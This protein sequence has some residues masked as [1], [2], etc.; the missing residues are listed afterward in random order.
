MKVL[1]VYAEFPI[2]YWGFQ[3]A[4]E[5]VGQKATLPP[6]GL[7]TLAAML[8]DDWPVR[9]IDLNAHTLNDTDIRWAD[10]VMVGGMLIQTD[11]MV[12][13]LT[14]A[15]RLGKRTVVGGP[16]PTTAP[17]LFVAADVVF[18][19]EA[20]GRIESLAEAIAA[21]GRVTLDAPEDRPD[22]TTSPIPRYN[23]LTLSD[24]SSVSLQYSRGCP[25]LCEF[26]DIIEIF[27]RRPRVKDAEQVF[28]EL[29]A[30][31]QVG[32]R[33]RIFFVDDN[34]IGNRR[35]VRKML[36]SI[37]AFQKERNYP[38]SFYTEATVDLASDTKLTAEMVL[39]GF[40]SV[41]LGI[42]TPSAASLRESGKTQNLRI[43]LR[44]AI[45]ILT[46]AGLEIMGGFIVG[47]DNDD[48][49]IFRLQR[50]FISDAPIPL[51]MVG[52]LAALPGTALWRRLEKEGRLRSASTGDQ[53]GRPNFEP[54]MDERVLLEGY[55]KLMAEVYSAESYY[56]RCRAHIDNAGPTPS[57]QAL[58]S[59]A[60]MKDFGR[61][62]VK[63]GILSPRR[64]QF[65]SLLAH[66]ARRS[67]EKLEWMIIHAFQG[68]H[69]IRYTDEHVIPRLEE[70]IREAGRE[71]A[72]AAEDRGVAAR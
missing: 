59:R 62:V 68:E 26:C 69:L 67:P 33:G 20:E 32:Y 51:A 25:Y 64:R 60:R 36:P 54:N 39:A 56:R 2:T 52:L 46:E 10:V 16:A 72:R 30:L 23:L 31:Y 58:P 41:F 28:E 71:S 34:F 27:G 45:D 9:L 5:M 24:Y 35:A 66:T 14:R 43:D 65:W 37:T 42:E 4:T 11:S 50:E 61:S 1:L 29:D 18:R 63:I 38:F 7:L 70:A 22:L 55:A 21:S 15:H 53:F 12:E 13:T 17:E 3:Y 57:P 44:S 47:F 19:G 40:G 48:Q 8:P 6:L 49:E